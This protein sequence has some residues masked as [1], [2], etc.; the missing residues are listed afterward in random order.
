MRI[1]LFTDAY[2][3]YI[4][5]VV[6]SVM[7]HKKTLEAMGHEVYVVTISAD[8][9]KYSY[10]EKEKVLKVPGIESGIYKDI[11]VT[12]IYPIYTINKIKKWKLDVIHSHTEWSIG[13]FAR[14]IGKQFGIPIVHTYHTLYQ[15]Y[16]YLVTKGYFNKPAEKVLEYFTLFYCDKTV[17]EL[18]VPTKKT[19]D[20][21]KKKYKIERNIH[22]IPTGT[23]ISKFKKSKINQKEV[24]EIKKSV[25]I[26]N[27]DIVLLVVSRISKEKSIDFLVDCHKELLKNNKN[28]KLVI[29]GDGPML[30]ELQEKASKIGNILFI[31]KVPWDQIQLYYQLGDI[32]VTASKTETQGLTVNEALASS[33][34]VV[35]V[36]DDSFK[37]SVIDGFNGYFFKTKKDYVNKINLLADDKTLRTTL[38]KQAE[39][40]SINFSTKHF[41]ESIIKVYDSA[42]KKG[43]KNLIQKIKK[44]LVRK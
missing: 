21:F 5:G 2:Y 14:I 36:E 40:Y 32:F 17:A 7:I 43:N 35:C 9:T 37:L 25:G 10:D 18:I 8:D 23:N 30:E 19:Y 13:T 15:D 41:G 16:M 4:S 26:S 22:I 44:I 12:T 38:S 20:I 42:I 27:K 1:G 31:G 39:D 6:T 3:P 24:N 34:P 33:L 29:I 11:K 28:I